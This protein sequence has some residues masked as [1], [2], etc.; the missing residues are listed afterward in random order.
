MSIHEQF[1]EDLA[2]YS[3]GVLPG[4]ERIAL[5]KHLTDCNSC[6][7]ELEYLRGDAALLA[8]SASG[9]QP[10]ERARLRLLK[11]IAHES[12]V[13]SVPGKKPA[14]A[15]WGALGWA[16][17]AA[18]LLVTAILWQQGKDLRQSVAALQSQS[19]QSQAELQKAHELVNVL[20]TPDAAHFT[21]VAAK[22]PP[23]PQGKAIY[24]RDCGNLIFLA[25]NMPP[26]PA[27]KIY[28]LWLIPVNGAPVPAGLFK[29]DAHGSA[30]VVNP[31]LPLGME[32]KA[33]AITVEP[34]VG[35]HMAP[36]STPI[37]VGA[38]E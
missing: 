17:T 12:R 4:D 7:Q 22:A 16:A 19:S 1:G 5:E 20:T 28:E 37:M 9:P 2:L 33:F 21:L 34:E 11:A 38:G 15:W 26:L 8:L 23:Q 13:E 35:E 29:P 18:M 32:A 6:R 10:P 27:E 14:F 36:T 3:L 25:N 31:P 30:T 24:V